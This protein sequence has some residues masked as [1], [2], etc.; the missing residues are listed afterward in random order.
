VRRPKRIES[1]TANQ[2]EEIRRRKHVYR[3]KKKRPTATAAASRP[4][5]PRYGV[6]RRGHLYLLPRRIAAAAAT[7]AATLNSLL[8][9]A[10]FSDSSR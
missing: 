1:A 4:A 9:E 6:N 7:T 5:A 3:R 2:S 8:E 10:E